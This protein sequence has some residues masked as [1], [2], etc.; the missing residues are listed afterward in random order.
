MDRGPII[1]D[2]FSEYDRDIELPGVGAEVSKHQTFITFESSWQPQDYGLPS[3]S[4]GMSWRPW[5]WAAGAIMFVGVGFMVWRAM[6]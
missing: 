3:E 4:D 6:K 2:E 1:F 5:L